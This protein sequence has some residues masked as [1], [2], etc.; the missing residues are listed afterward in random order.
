MFCLHAVR[1][2][3]III[4]IFQLTGLYKEDGGSSSNKYENF[5]N[6]PKA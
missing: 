4:V 2:F 6:D 5:E 3:F 1:V